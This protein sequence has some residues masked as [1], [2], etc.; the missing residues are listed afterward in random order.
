MWITVKILVF[1]LNEIESHH[2]LFSRGMT[3]TIKT[4]RRIILAAVFKTKG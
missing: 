1:T 4:F 2:R 3:D